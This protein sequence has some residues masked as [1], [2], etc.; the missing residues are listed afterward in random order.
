MVATVLDLERCRLREDYVNPF[1]HRLER[2]NIDTAGGVIPGVR[3]QGTRSRNKR[4]YPLETL[5]EAL[6]LYEGAFVYFRPHTKKATD[7]YDPRDKIGWIENCR[8]TEDGIYGDLH[9]LLSHE[10]ASRILEAAQKN[11]RLY[12]L[13]HDADGKLTAPDENGYK[14][15]ESISAVFALD[16]VDRGGSNDSL[17]EDFSMPRTVTLRELIQNEP[18]LSAEVKQRL[19][20]SDMPMDQEIPM[21]ETPPA[22]EEPE[23]DWKECLGEA[24]AALMK[25]DDPKAHG[26]M[27]K[28]IA[29][30]RPESEQSPIPG[31][32][33][34]PEIPVIKNEEE[35][36]EI[37]EEDEDMPA[38]K[39]EVQ[40][41]RA[42][43][44]R[45]TEERDQFARREAIREELAPLNITDKNARTRLVES[46]SLLP[47]DKAKQAI[48][49]LQEHV[50]K[51][52]QR[53]RE[54]GPR[55]GG[56]PAPV[57]VTPMTNKE[58]ADAC[59][60]K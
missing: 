48:K 57:A 1:L 46:L 60:R 12:A 20:E 45:L 26:I 5:R 24:I 8:L 14:R 7:A 51:P 11:P 49:D 39:E 9:L 21:P 42:D 59:R 38:M 54:S 43:V 18:R 35:E 44:D 17:F 30:L 6:H 32:K 53:L 56:V 36:E 10:H 47:A 31:S 52:G 4:L 19:L 58:L 22:P 13:S 16:L 40:K 3:V 2:G 28:L 25:H 23:K 33:E 55:S 15:V 34:Q 29:I 41:L 37:P 27:E 50:I